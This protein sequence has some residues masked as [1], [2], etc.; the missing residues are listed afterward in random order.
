MS[1]RIRFSM[2]FEAGEYREISLD[3]GRPVKAYNL[4]GNASYCYPVK[5]S[6]SNG[7]IPRFSEA[8]STDHRFLGC[9]IILETNP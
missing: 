1:G 2:K 5:I 3:P 7:F 9:H 4:A 6:V 8:G